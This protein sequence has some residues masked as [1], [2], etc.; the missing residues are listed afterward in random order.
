M[1]KQAGV[2]RAIAEQF[3]LVMIFIHAAHVVTALGAEFPGMIIISSLPVTTL[4]YRLLL[5]FLSMHAGAAPLCAGCSFPVCY[6]SS[7]F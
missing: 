3:D 5:C 4:L 6:N 7:A 2:G 1:A